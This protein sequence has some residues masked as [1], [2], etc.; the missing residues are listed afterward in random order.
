MA[1]IPLVVS[2]FALV[3][4]S[5]QKFKTAAD[6]CPKGTH[7]V[8]VTEEYKYQ[9]SKDTKEITTVKD[10]SKGCRDNKDSQIEERH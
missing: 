5:E 1:M 4:K 7:E 3:A 10:T 2:T 9:V 8:I 6:P